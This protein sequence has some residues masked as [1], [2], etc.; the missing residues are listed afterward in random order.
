[1]PQS[2][3]QERSDPLGAAARS[4]EQSGVARDEVVGTPIV[5]AW[6]MVRGTAK[7]RRSP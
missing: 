1:M 4:L 5:A 6:A 7:R 3:N 2:V